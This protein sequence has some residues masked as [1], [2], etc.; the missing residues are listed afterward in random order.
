MY[1]RSQ[2]LPETSF[3]LFGPRGT[4]KSSWVGT[5]L[6]QATCIDLLEADTFVRLQSAPERLEGMVSGRPGSWVVIDEV[7]KIPPL[8]DEVHRLIE[9]RK[10]RFALTGSSARKLRRGGVNLLAGRARTLDMLPLTAREL[11]RDFDLAHAV[12]YGGLPGAWVEKDPAGFLAAYVRTYL[13]EEVR[14]EGVTRNLAGFTRFLEAAS[15]SQAS[16]LNISAVARDC[17]VERKTVEQWFQAL[18]DLLL[19]VRLPV[20]TRRAKRALTAHPRFFLFDAGVYRTLRPRGPLDSAA[21]ID[22]PALETFV[23]NELRAANSYLRL[24]YTI[25]TWRT[26]G[27]IEVD[28]VLYGERG[29]HAIEV[30]RSASVRGDSLTGLRLFAADYPVAKRWLLYGGSK[31]L[32]VDDVECVPLQEIRELLAAIC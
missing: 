5:A 7:Q 23:L 13:E 29:L 16:V 18:E 1:A 26:E 11:G 3:F 27:G 21:E 10:W 19:A 2:T 8:L 4:G 24:G 15:F 6:A 14:Q 9:K 20:F 12:R 25:S 32:R 28:F 22:G 30:K 17:G 31:R